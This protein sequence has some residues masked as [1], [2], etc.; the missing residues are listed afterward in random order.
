MTFHIHRRASALALSAAAVAITCSSLT[1]PADA[2][3]RHYSDVATYYKAT[4]QACKVSVDDGAKWRI[5]G[6]LDNTRNR[7]ADKRSGSVIMVHNDQVTDRRIDTG[8]VA[9]GQVSAVKSIVVPKG[10]AYS[11][12]VGVGAGQMG[13][14]GPVALSALR[15]C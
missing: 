13:N 5:F 10:S 15:R 6:R 8:Y 11:L 3:G 7:R 4:V 2:A 14:G 9:G 12:A 1:A